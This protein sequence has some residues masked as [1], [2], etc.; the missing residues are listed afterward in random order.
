MGFYEAATVVGLAVGAA[1][2]GRLHDQFGSL[3]FTIVAVLY[4]LALVPFLLVRD[5]GLV[6][7]VRTSHSGMLPGC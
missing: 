7:R 1:L 4:V 6:P 2:G 3:S 5:R